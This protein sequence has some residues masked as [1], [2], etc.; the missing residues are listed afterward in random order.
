[1]FP[2]RASFTNTSLSLTSIELF[3]E[4]PERVQPIMKFEDAGLHPAMLKNVELSGYVVP[5]PIQKYCL[6]AIHLGY[7][8]IGIAQTGSGKTAAYLIPILNKLM[9]KAK[10][11]AAPR[12]CPVDESGLVPKVRAEPLVVIVCPTRELAIQ[13]FT[14]AR[15][16]CYRTM[17]R[18][19]VIYG[20]G[21]ISEQRKQLQK[22]CDVLIASPGRL[23]DFM[24]R[25]DLLTLRRVKYMV[26]DEADEML[27]DD[28]AEDLN[29]ILSGGGRFRRYHLSWFPG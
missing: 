6:P 23:I 2:A 24:E 16:F 11:L 5:T 9:G 27:H 13:I 20:G 17:L 4:G 7:D 14:E 21:P 29:K 1:M 28:W 3:Q 19:S 10:K 8:V 18:P 12:P 15:K 26:I 25:P 22:G